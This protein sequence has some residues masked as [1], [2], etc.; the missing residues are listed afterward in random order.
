MWLQR[1]LKGNLCTHCW[2]FPRTDEHD[3]PHVLLKKKNPY[4][5][6]EIKIKSKLEI[7]THDVSKI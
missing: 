4:V 2:G 5:I 7:L 6:P 3:A 1:F